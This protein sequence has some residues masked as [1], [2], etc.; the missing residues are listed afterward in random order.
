MTKLTITQSS[1]P[2]FDVQKP[3]VINAHD[4]VSNNSKTAPWKF[5]LENNYTCFPSAKFP[6]KLLIRGFVFDSKWLLIDSTGNITIRKEYAWDG[7]S[8]KINIMDLFLFGIP[9]GIIDFHTFKPKTYYASLVHDALYQYSSRLPVKRKSAD[10]M[11]FV[12]LRK[13]DFQLA[14][15]YYWAVRLIGWMY[16]DKYKKKNN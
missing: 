13:N 15:L 3:V 7:C 5:K 1:K 2:T 12:L 10:K 6:K 4:F 16:W 14:R 9:D 8:P 11:F